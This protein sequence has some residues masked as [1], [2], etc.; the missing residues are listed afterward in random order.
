MAS[1]KVT[2]SGSVT[3]PS[4]IRHSMGIHSG[5]PIDLEV[6]GDEIHIKKHTAVCFFCGNVNKVRLYEGIEI[7]SE[8]AEHIGKECG[9][10]G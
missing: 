3:I 4:Q 6:V 9:S 8:C 10:D 2:R 7:C 1:K 5:T